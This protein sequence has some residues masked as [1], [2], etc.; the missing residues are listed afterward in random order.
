MKK[1]ILTAI[2]GIGLMSVSCKEFLEPQSQN[3]FVPKT[4]Q[5]L[6]EL[7]VS[8][9]YL[10]PWDGSHH[11]MFTALG[12]FDDDVTWYDKEMEIRE[13]AQ[14]T[15]EQMR[16]PYA[17]DDA[18]LTDMSG[19]G[20]TYETSYQRIVGCNVVLDYADDMH[21][22]ENERAKLKAQAYAM[23][24]FY[25]FYL[26]NTY[27]KPYS[28]DKEALGVPLKITSEFASSG[29]PRSTVGKVYEQM[30]TDL[31]EAERLFMLLPEEEQW[32][33]TAFKASLPMVQLLLSRVYLYM[34]EWESAIKYAEKVILNPDFQLLD[35]STIEEPKINAE[36]PYFDYH[37]AENPETI[38]LYG[39]FCDVIHLTG[40][41]VIS[42]DN[43]NYPLFI[44]S[45]SLLNSFVPS[46]LRKSRYIFQSAYNDRFPAGLRAVGKSKTQRGFKFY[47]GQPG[48]GWGGSLRLCEA[49]LNAIEGAVMLYKNGNHTYLAEALRRWDELRQMR[50][51]ADYEKITTTDP[52]LLMDL[53]RRER[54]CELCF[55]HHR[56]FDIRRYGMEPLEHVW[57][58]AKGERVVYKLEK[59]DPG[60]TLLLPQSAIESNTKLEQNELRE[61]SESK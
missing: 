48:Y 61:K 31:Q 2:C 30:V 25:Y 36:N 38:F 54:R 8:D 29:I 35:L 46:D 24:A 16:L 45:E 33:P 42:E 41:F 17:W 12:V 34:E 22:S 60:F 47:Y 53:I 4:V 49:Y 10:G 55:E 27:G 59:N 26:V 56:W 37:T 14:S 57:Y 51:T 5:S 50:H 32:N 28:F 20:D 44:P 58:S 1:T 23:R 15:Y 19:F 21:G 52:D 13:S 3:E 40:N 7:L 11:P 6:N 39:S 18:M 43:F 9:V